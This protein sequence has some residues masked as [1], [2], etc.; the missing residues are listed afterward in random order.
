MNEEKKKKL[1]QLASSPEIKQKMAALKKE[2]EVT[3]GKII[4]FWKAQGIELTE[5]DLKTPSYEMSDDELEAVSGGGG[6]GCCGTGGGWGDLLHCECILA[7]GGSLAYKKKDG[8]IRE[9]GGDKI[10]QYG[11]CFCYGGGAGATNWG[12][13]SPHV[14]IPGEYDWDE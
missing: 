13:V 12:N 14:L 11:G 9:G 5:D 4:D 10:C 7:G 1:K 6:C 2:G 8:T 3:E